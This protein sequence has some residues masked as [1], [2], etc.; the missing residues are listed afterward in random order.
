MLCKYLEIELN[1]GTKVAVEC[2]Q[3][4]YTYGGLLAGKPGAVINRH[5]FKRTA[6]PSNWGIRKTLKIKPTKSEFKN[7]LKPAYYVVWLWGDPF[8]NNYTKYCGSELVVI[9][10]GDYPNG[11][12]IET[13]IEEGVKFIDWQK[14]AKDFCY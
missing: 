6:S 8:D 7:C 14:N 10:F 12:T 13:I 2:F 4:G 5:I 9:W 1:C 3:L 11:K